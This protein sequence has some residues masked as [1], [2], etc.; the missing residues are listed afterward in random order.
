MSKRTS[1]GRKPRTK[2]SQTHRQSLCRRGGGRGVKFLARRGGA[3]NTTRDSIL[4]PYDP[5]LQTNTLRSV[6][7]DLDM[8]LTVD[9]AD[10]NLVETMNI[11]KSRAE[12][13]Q[14]RKT[15]MQGG[16]KGKSI[17][18]G[19]IR[20]SRGCCKRRK[21]GCMCGCEVGCGCRVGCVCGCPQQKRKTRQTRQTRRK[22][23]GGAAPGPLR[24]LWWDVQDTI[25]TVGSAAF[26]SPL[27]GR[28][29][30]IPKFIGKQVELMPKW[31]PG[32]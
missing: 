12:G 7:S 8:P 31:L 20:R 25:D 5:S 22:Q 13:D 29:R 14:T 6:T 26:G 28:V 3:R 9:P 4:F 1:S 30:G 11:D 17:Q 16:K 27:A 18:G 32:A 21:G 19:R 15:V 2:R 10:L 24:S 23:R